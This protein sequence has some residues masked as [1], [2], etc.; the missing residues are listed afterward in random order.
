MSLV[1]SIN[2]GSSSVK[3][4][5]YSSNFN[6]TPSLLV[7]SSI[8]GLTAPPAT[9]SYSSSFLNHF[10]SDEAIKKQP[11]GGTIAF[12]CH[13]IVHGGTFPKAVVLNSETL[14]YLDE[15]TDLAPLSVLLS[16]PGPKNADN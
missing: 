7:N 3:L 9:F 2:T 1:L 11:H 8:S 5:L 16:A 14:R 12:A 15:L 4:S 6:S 13:R 10:T